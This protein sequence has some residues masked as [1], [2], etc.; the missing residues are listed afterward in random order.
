[1]TEFD[2]P[3]FK[4]SYDLYKVFYGFRAT[5][6]K[7]DRYTIWQRSETLMIELIESIVL[8]S[9]MGKAEKLPT[10]ERA[11]S[12]ISVIRVLI[13]LMKEVKAIDT[14]KYVAL[15]EIVDEIGRMLGGWI[16]SVKQP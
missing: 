15:E 1:M 13:R 14:K 5:V 4:K 16:R 2:I 9:Q 8:G 11:S 12:K 6:P 10:L 3:V 7:Q